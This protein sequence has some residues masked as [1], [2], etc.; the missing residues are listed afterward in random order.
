MLSLLSRLKDC[1]AAARVL[2]KTKKAD[3]ITPVL[4][5]LHWLP[6]CQR[7]E[8]KI[9]LIVYKPL[10]GLQP[11][12][13]SDLLVCYEPTRA[14]RSSEATLLTVPRVQTKHGEAAV[15]FN[16]P[17]IWNKLSEHVRSN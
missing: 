3:H 14:L 15:S 12:H 4:R 13:I 5:S 10:N 2:T 7:I 11:K 1:N 16:A 17:Q 6:V 8:F 9:L